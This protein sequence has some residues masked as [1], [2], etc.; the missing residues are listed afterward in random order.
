MVIPVAP[1]D[2]DRIWE[3]HERNENLDSTQIIRL[4]VSFRVS[5]HLLVVAVYVKIR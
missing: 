3:L 1:I 2:V 5:L 4:D